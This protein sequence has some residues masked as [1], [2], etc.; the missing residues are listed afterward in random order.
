VKAGVSC[1]GLVGQP[2]PF[3]P[4]LISKLPLGVAGAVPDHGVKLEVVV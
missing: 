2:S 4:L 1:R 3:G